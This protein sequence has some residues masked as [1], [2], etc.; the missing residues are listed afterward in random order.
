MLQ[1]IDAEAI[2]VKIFGRL[3]AEAMKSLLALE[4]L[5]WSVL[6]VIKALKC[7]LLLLRA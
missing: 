6:S 5:K 2:Q 3:I 1:R 7:E 4:E